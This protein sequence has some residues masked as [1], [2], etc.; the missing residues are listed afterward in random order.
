MS[1]TLTK[2]DL[3]ALKQ[4]VDSSI[5]NR[6]SA[7]IDERVPAI[8]NARVQPMLD[9][10]EAKL[11]KRLLYKFDELNGKIED[12]R[13]DVGKFSLETTNNF[14]ELRDKID[15]SGRALLKT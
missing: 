13:R 6:F 11:D 4:L 2:D 1:M 12:L 3:Q 15:R 10:L 7:I 9:R 8:I 5:D 14:M